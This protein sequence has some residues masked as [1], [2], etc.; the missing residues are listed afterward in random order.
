MNRFSEAVHKA[1]VKP[2]PAP[3]QPD[4]ARL[5]SVP[6][7]KRV[8][9]REV[10][11]AVGLSPAAVSYALRGIQVSEETQ[12]RVRQVASDLGYEAH[13]IARALASGRT[14][15]IG[16][17][18]PSLEDLW[19]QHLMAEAGR[20][21]LERDQYALILDAGGDP[22]R[23]RALAA[24]LRDQQVDGLIV[25]PIDPTDSFWPELAESLA[26]VSIGDELPGAATAGEVLFDNHAGVRSALEHLYALGHRQIAVFRPP[27]SPTAGRPAEMFVDAEAGRLGIDVMIH[28]TP[29]ALPG[30]TE[31]AHAVLTGPNRPSAAFCFSDSL[32]YGVYAAARDLNVRIP[33]DLSLIGYDDHPVSSLLTPQLTSFSWDT[34]RLIEAAVGMV[35]A[36][37]DGTRRPQRVVIEPV[38]RERR[39][40]SRRS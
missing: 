5:G 35:L 21:L 18:G 9:I 2:P 38:L 30:A 23:Q 24:Q 27:G 19:Q 16:I 13:P 20:T 14:G 28:S 17:L 32:A 1:L 12:E 4:R 31:V 8:T 6:L 36:A 37:I 39:S 29:Y 7:A 25:S 34:E 26:L 33:D 22:A 40:T 11:D 3:G 15:M 10:A